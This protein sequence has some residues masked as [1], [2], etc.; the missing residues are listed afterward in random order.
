[1]EGIHGLNEL[2]TA[3]I[4]AENKVKIYISAL[5][6]LNIDLHNR[7]PT[8]ECRKI[9]RIVRDSQ[10]RGYTAEDTLTR[11]DAVRVG[12]DKY[13]FPFQEEADYMFNSTLTY[14]LGVLRKYA[15]PLLRT[16][17][18]KSPVYNQAQDLI[19]LFEHFLDIK[20][21]YVPNNSLLREFMSNS[22][23]EY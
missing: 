18:Y 12:E 4:P 2:L 6:Q 9:R 11:W 7:I 19:A 22:I 8:T 15:M 20:D 13:I 16:I 3:S 10:Y 17:N 5:N 1:M 14:E 21:D 23:F